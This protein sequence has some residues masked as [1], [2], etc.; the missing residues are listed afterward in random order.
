MAGTQGAKAELNGRKRHIV[1]DTAGVIA[2]CCGAFGGDT[3]PGWSEA[4]N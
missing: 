2:L 4:G 3:E 1:V